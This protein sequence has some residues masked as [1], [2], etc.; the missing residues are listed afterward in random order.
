[1]K[2]FSHPGKKEFELVDINHLIELTVTVA[3][4]EWKTCAELILDLSAN[5]TPIRSPIPW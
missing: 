2:E 4:N 3:R 5:S 1:M